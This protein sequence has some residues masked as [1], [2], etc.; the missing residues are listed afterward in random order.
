[1]ALWPWRVQ[2]F[3]IEEKEQKMARIELLI[4]FSMMLLI[5]VAAILIQISHVSIAMKYTHG[6]A[7]FHIYIFIAKRLQ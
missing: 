1:M 2:L 3:K 5:C 4:P 6:N 7:V